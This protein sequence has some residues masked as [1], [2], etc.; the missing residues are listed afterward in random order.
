[1]SSNHRSNRE[2]EWDENEE[3]HRFTR[4]ENS[5][6]KKLR[7][8]DNQQQKAVRKD[9]THISLK[10][11]H[12]NKLIIIVNL[13]NWYISETFQ[14]KSSD[15]NSFKILTE[16]LKYLL[17]VLKSTYWMLKYL[18]SVFF[19][20]SGSAKEANKSKGKPEQCTNCDSNWRR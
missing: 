20:D 3:K 18:L 14:A 9:I 6:Y 5:I 19:A 13:I 2:I 11:S 4:K 16:C 1:M 8:Y 15:N 10:Q 7:T 12:S 17:R